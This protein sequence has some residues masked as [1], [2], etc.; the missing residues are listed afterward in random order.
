M[1][2]FVCVCVN[3]RHWKQTLNYLSYKVQGFVK[4][5]CLIGVTLPFLIST[6]VNKQS[7]CQTR[8]WEQQLTTASL[9]AS[10]VQV[11]TMTWDWG[12]QI[13]YS[14]SPPFHLICYCT[15]LPCSLVV[16]FCVFFKIF[17]LLWLISNSRLVPLAGDVCHICFG[18]SVRIKTK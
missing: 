2:F 9:P 6:T 10:P 15:G 12:K 7:L 17:F 1:S 4:T 3:V 13:K 11:Q 8:W 16:F 5:Q 18:R 14:Q